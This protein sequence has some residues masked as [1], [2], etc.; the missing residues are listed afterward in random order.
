MTMKPDFLIPEKYFGHF[1]LGGSEDSQHLA[2]FDQFYPIAG[3]LLGLSQKQSSA[4]FFRA[5]AGGLKYDPKSTSLLSDVLEIYSK[6]TNT[7]PKAYVFP[8]MASDRYQV[9]TQ[10]LAPAEQGQSYR[11]KYWISTSAV[12]A[13]ISVFF[14]HL[15]HLFVLQARKVPQ[16]RAAQAEERVEH[17]SILCRFLNTAIHDGGTFVF[18]DVEIE[19]CLPDAERLCRE[20]F[21]YSIAFSIFHEVAHIELGHFE[22]RGAGLDASAKFAQELEAD[23]FALSHAAHL[24]SSTPWGPLIGALVALLGDS[25]SHKQVDSHDGTAHP[26]L[27]RR[28]RALSETND[29]ASS[30]ELGTSWDF[31]APYIQNLIVNLFDRDRGPCWFGRDRRALLGLPQDYDF[32]QGPSRDFRSAGMRRTTDPNEAKAAEK[33]FI[34]KRRDDS[35]T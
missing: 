29:G 26:S 31:A 33:K 32:D 18:E 25:L 28:F 13:Y 20:I 22:A 3:A 35:E 4:L 17:Y 24:R 19:P 23:S 2:F 8:I 9:L 16:E 10:S 11:I 27:V 12:S 1:I 14:A 34:W 30:Y 15:F 21:L 7:Q 6:I 5:S